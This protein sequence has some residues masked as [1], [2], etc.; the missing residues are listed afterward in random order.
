MCPSVRCYGRRSSTPSTR[1]VHPFERPVRSERSIDDYTKTAANNR[2][3]LH[4]LDAV[5]SEF[6]ASGIEALPLKGADLLGRAYG[7]ALGLRPMV[8]VDLLVHHQDLPQIE[9]ILEANG[10]QSRASGNPVYVFPNHFLALDMISDIWYLES[11]DAVWQR[12]VCRQV[13]GRFRRAMHPEDAL[14]YL[15]AYQ[16]IHRG[17]LGR[18]MALDVAALLDAE[19]Q[20]IDWDNVVHQANTRHLRLPL[21]HGL[22]YAHDKTGARIPT[23]VLDALRPEDSQHRIAS[24]YQRLVTEQGIPGLGHLLLILSLRGY[25]HKLK[26]LWKALFPSRDFLAFRYGERNPC[27]WLWIRLSRPAYLLFRGG[28]LLLRI[29]RRLIETR[30]FVQSDKR[31]QKTC[32]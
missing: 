22:A 18:Q 4:R 28:L 32:N 16:T 6:E 29:G 15:A 9:R 19:G 3:R 8:D 14:I 7:G 26:A 5:L 21:Y 10:F 12:S 2:R 25:K 24:L 1:Y 23:W 13:A 31:C 17:R 20:L 11:I 30:H 27:E